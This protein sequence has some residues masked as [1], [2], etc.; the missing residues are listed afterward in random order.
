MVI[1]LD[2]PANAP[3]RIGVDLDET[4]YVTEERIHIACIGRLIIFR[5]YGPIGCRL[6]VQKWMPWGDIGDW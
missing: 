2:R 5:D 3:D 6:N 4:Q 1:G